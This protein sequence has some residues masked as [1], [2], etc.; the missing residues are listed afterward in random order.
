MCKCAACQFCAVAALANGVSTRAANLSASELLMRQV[1]AGEQRARSTPPPPPV[2]IQPAAGGAIELSP[3]QG[4]LCPSLSRLWWEERT[5]DGRSPAAALRLRLRDWEGGTA[6]TAFVSRAPGSRAAP[7]LHFEAVAGAAA[8]EAAGAAGSH[9]E[10]RRWITAAADTD[11]ASAAAFAGIQHASV[12]SAS[13][14]FAA[15]ASGGAQLAGLPPGMQ[16]LSIRLQQPPDSPA[17][18]PDVRLVGTSTFASPLVVC[19]APPPTTRKPG[20]GTDPRTNPTEAGHLASSAVSR[21]PHPPPPAAVSATGSVAHV[22]SVSEAD[23]KDAGGMAKSA[24]HAQDNAHGAWPATSLPAAGISHPTGGFD[25]GVPPGGGATPFPPDSSAGHSTWSGFH[26]LVGLLVIGVPVWLVYSGKSSLVRPYSTS[27]RVPTSEDFGI[28]PW[29][30]EDPFL[31]KEPAG[32]AAE[33][34]SASAEYDIDPYAD[35]RAGDSGRAHRGVNGEERGPRRPAPPAPLTAPAAAPMSASTICA[36][37]AFEE[38]TPTASSPSCSWPHAPVPVLPAPPG[39]HRPALV[40]GRGGRVGGGAHGSILTWEDDEA[41]LH[42][43]AA[44]PPGRR[45]KLSNDID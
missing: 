41:Q 5:E 23:S 15:A 30:D 21:L 35:L 40:G 4:Q 32:P 16:A 38:P 36:S 11:A 17:A 9:V 25:G 13:S 45:K 22:Q 2:A 34:A 3:L 14:A 26:V 20:V 6:L 44:A 31:E 1:A 12:S 8:G 42:S 29:E 10:T 24:P 39:S 28:G 7:S 19:V 18:W 43:L 37:E 33:Q 27:Q